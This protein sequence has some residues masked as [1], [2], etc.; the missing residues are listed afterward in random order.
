MKN[1]K[2]V[3]LVVALALPL[4]VTY[5]QTPEGPV[6]GAPDQPQAAPP[7]NL[8]P[9]AAEVIRL[10]TSGVGDDVV[11]AYIQNSQTPFN[12]SADA[13]VYLK[14]VGLSP[15]VTTAMLNHD[16]TMQHQPQQYAPAA[17]A[18]PA[19]PP[20]APAVQP[21]PAAAPAPAYV[22][23]APADVSYFYDSLAPYGTWVSLEGYGWCWQPRT[24]VISPAWRPYCDSG[25]WVYTDAGWFWQSDYSW[26]WA[27]FHYGRWYQHP[28]CGWVWTPDRV[29]G[30][31]WV[32][33]RTTGDY[34]GWAPLP[35]HADFDVHLGWRFNG[36]RVGAS[37]DFGLGVG[38]FAF[39]SFGDF[40][41]HD[42]GHHRLPPARV[43][44]VYHQTTI[45]NNYVVEHNTIV[46]RGI[47]VERVSSASHVPVPHATVRDLPAG[48]ARTPSHSTAVVYRHEL[49]APA[50]PVHME[51]QRVDV[52]HPVIQHP[53]IAPA[54]PGRTS[55]FSHNA[56]AP[57]SAQRR[58]GSIES[59]KVSP[60]SSSSNP[61]ASPQHQ[62]PQKNMQ[63]APTP[64]ARPSP[65]SGN[66]KPAE[67][68]PTQPGPRS[69]QP[70]S[71]SSAPK[72][73]TW[74]S[75]TQPAAPQ[76]THAATRTS[77]PT[78][79]TLPTVTAPRAPE[80]WKQGNHAAPGYR[81]DSGLPA[82]NNARSAGQPTPAAP[83]TPSNPHVYAPKS[84]RQAA[85]V[86][87]LPKSEQ[88][89][90]SAPAP[91]AGGSSSHSRK[92]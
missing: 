78:P 20:V 89:E 13:V 62:P 38:A 6:T 85:E 28:R 34:C 51:A 25:H 80:N 40:C 84:A 83:Q 33:W 30:P 53:P 72:T 8:S 71:A 46:H 29:W 70:G 11:L 31:A 7:V 44:T 26:G 2:W 39:V 23:S 10:A 75:S 15:Q 49:K 56:S 64:G 32:T 43:T 60:W 36:V 22:T 35:P 19:P 48:S 5:S 74:T 92:D 24:V 59:P 69:P 81:S 45:V 41:S 4:P 3:G 55:A 66:P 82:L 86:H 47:P 52:S 90:S 91:A 73:Y 12:L 76:P 87:S 50:R 14:D 63:P 1:L 58:G 37:F 68:K 27:P 16:S 18:Q 21:P 57:P 54:N 65:W 88:H 61:A 9:G 77:Q 17:P 79:T 67:P 42:L